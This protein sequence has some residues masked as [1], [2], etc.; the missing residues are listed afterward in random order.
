MGALLGG[1]MHCG[2]AWCIVG[3]E[4]A[5]WGSRRYI[6]GLLDALWLGE[7]PCDWVHCGVV[8]CIVG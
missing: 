7:L 8:G 4:G 3:L 1:W 5:L 2:M 6:M